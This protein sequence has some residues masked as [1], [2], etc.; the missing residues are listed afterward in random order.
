MYH[1]EVPVLI[2]TDAAVEANKLLGDAS[3][4]VLVVAHTPVKAVSVPRRTGTAR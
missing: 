4:G 2:G 1:D 3:V